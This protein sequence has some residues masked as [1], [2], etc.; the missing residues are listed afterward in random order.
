[1]LIQGGKIRSGVLWT[2]LGAR[3]VLDQFEHAVAE[4]DLALGRGDVAA[5]LEGVPVG[6]RHQQVAVVR[7]DVPHEVLKPPHK[8]FALGLDRPGQRLGVGAE[9][10]AGLNMSIS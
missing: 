6:Q 9:K 3:R 10:F 2:V 1:L 5:D 4:D 8:A 7:L